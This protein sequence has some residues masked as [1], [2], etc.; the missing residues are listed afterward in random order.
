M[1]HLPIL[2]VIIPLMAAPACLLLRKPRLAWLVSL[3]ATGTAFLISTEL[4]QQVLRSGT[5][6]Y[7]IGGW[8]APWGIEYRIDLLSAYLLIIISAVSFVILLSASTSIHS[9]LPKERHIYFYILYLLCVAGMLGIVATGDLFNVFVFLEISALSSYALIALGDNRRALFAS[10]QYLVMGVIAASFILIGIGLMYVMTGTL[11]MHDLSQRLPEVSDSRTVFTAFTFFVVGI[12]LKLALF[13]LHMWLPGAY[14]FAPSIVTAFLAATATKVA[15]YL[16]IRI[17][18]F[19]FGINYFL[20]FPLQD[21]F[22]ALGLT[23]VLFASVTAIFQH[24]VKCLLAYSSVAQI[25]YIVLGLGI[26]TTTGFTAAMVH[27]FNHTLMA[28]A[29]FLAVGAVMYR[30]GGV[31]LEDFAGLG[32]QMPWTMA[33][34]VV[35]GL[36][37]IGVPLTVGFISKWY[38]VSAVLEQGWWSVAVFILMGSLIAAVYIW[39]IVEAAYF[40]V[41]ASENS[42]VAEAPLSLLLPMWILVLANIYFGLDTR[43]TVDISELIA[44]ILPGIIP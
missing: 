9:E 36:S 25:S 14:T 31:R 12:C 7:E 35:V 8:S 28:G 19:I 21:I 3:L 42:D 11:N 30:V 20:N 1:I 13:P 4:L 24:N 29:L 16:L 17:V 39:R 37:V 26:G 2:Q 5:I 15:L 34:I 41:S 38:L 44:N 6:I 33:A 22:L 10:F 43:L 40:Q 32:K 18:F 23:G 27:V